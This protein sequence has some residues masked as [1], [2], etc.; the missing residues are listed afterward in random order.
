MDVVLREDFIETQL[1]SSWDDWYEFFVFS[2]LR[3]VRPQTLSD[4]VIQA[5]GSD[6]RV[7]FVSKSGKPKSYVECGRVVDFASS[8]EVRYA[9]RKISWDCVVSIPS[10]ADVEGLEYYFASNLAIGSSEEYRPAFD[11]VLRDP[12][13]WETTPCADA[14]TYGGLFVSRGWFSFGKV[15]DGLFVGKG[16]DFDLLLTPELDGV[17][18]QDANAAELGTVICQDEILK[19]LDDILDSGWRIL[20]GHQHTLVVVGRAGKRRVR[21]E[22]ELIKKLA[23]SIANYLKR[24]FDSEWTVILGCVPYGMEEGHNAEKRR[25]CVL[26]GPSVFDL[27]NELGSILRD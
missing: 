12:D 16:V 6:G 5:M 7:N 10:D 20:P 21:V 17:S 24:K 13:K 25:L 26:G 4:I 19:E 3:V 15:F 23:K 2:R 18:A 22:Q 8:F 27:T 9:D 11:F 14:C 1:G